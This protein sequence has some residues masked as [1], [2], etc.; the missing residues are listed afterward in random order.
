MARDLGALFGDRGGREGQQAGAQQVRDAAKSV[1]I[2]S[3]N[4]FSSRFRTHGGLAEFGGFLSVAV[5]DVGELGGQGAHDAGCLFAR[6]LARGGSFPFRAGRAVVLDAL[7]DA[8]VCC[9]RGS[10]GKPSPWPR[11]RG[12]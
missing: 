8:V 2:L 6:C 5:P 1:Y 3:S 11:G 10:R 9:G 4:K 7:A 12:R